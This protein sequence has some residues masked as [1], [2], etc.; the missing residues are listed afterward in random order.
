MPPNF[1]GMEADCNV[2]FFPI[3]KVF[4]G[5]RMPQSSRKEIIKICHEKSIPHIGVTRKT[6]VFEMQECEIQCENC[7]QYTGKIVL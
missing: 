6:D 3:T 2:P 7:P 4:L 1:D 5:N